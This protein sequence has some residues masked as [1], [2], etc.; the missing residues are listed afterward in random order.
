MKKVC[1]VT[2]TR[3][4]YGLL[5]N[6][7]YRIKEDKDLV[8][9]LVVT[10]THLSQEFGMTINEILED[11]YAVDDKVEILLSSDTPGAVCKSMGL[12][13]IGFADVFERLR[14]D[15][16]IVLGDR[17]ELIPI[18][19]CA[20]NFR[21]PIT[22]I[23][24]GEV[25]SGAID[26]VFRHAITKM[27]YLH[28]P[29]CNEYRQRI[30]QLGEAPDRVFDYGD[31][32]VENIIHMKFK[33]QK[34]LEEII[35]LDLDKPTASVTFHPITLESKNQLELQMQ[36]LLDALEYFPDMNFIIT[37]AN[38]D[39]NGRYINSMIDEY[40]KEHHNMK[41][42]TSLGIR[43]YVSLLKLCDC[44]VGN[45]SSGIVEAPAL[46]VPTI[47]I[48]DRQKGRLMASSIIQCEPVSSQII[49]SIQLALSND[50]KQ[51]VARTVNPYGKGDTSIKI[52]ETIKEYLIQNKIDLKKG[53]YDIEY[54]E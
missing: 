17:Y 41:A 8:L 37:K 27:S 12:A 4:E 36:E 16:L 14:P 11:G 49:S 19:A 54:K 20:I 15:M 31:V 3:A 33:S 51:Q 29:G 52:V 26:D 39:A 18:C 6:T 28:F 2:A 53:F 46:K 38:A 43:N 7:I 34:E 22:H 10:G 23:S 50:F 48:G 13:S 40:V 47:N 44:V 5:K 45:S 21:I 25:T 30:I 9:Q 1:V 35:G 42:F 32:G 24:G